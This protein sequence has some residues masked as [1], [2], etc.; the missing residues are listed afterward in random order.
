MELKFKPKQKVWLIYGNKP[1]C[2]P[3]HEIRLNSKVEYY[4][5]HLDFPGKKDISIC[6]DNTFK[7]DEDKLFETKEDLIKSL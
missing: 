5:W 7:I 2:V 6:Y 3:I 1:V 4:F